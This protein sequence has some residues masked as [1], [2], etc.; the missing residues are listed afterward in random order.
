MT[1]DNIKPEPA[2]CKADVMPALIR[3]DTG[4][5]HLWFWVWAV[6]DRHDKRHVMTHIWFY[7]KGCNHR[8]LRL[9]GHS[10]RRVFDPLSHIGL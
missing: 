8:V 1:Y 5:N 3:H 6:E 9:R 4:H 7:M 10:R 2:C